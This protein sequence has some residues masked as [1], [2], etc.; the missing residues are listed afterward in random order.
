MKKTSTIF[1]L[2]WIIFQLIP[3]NN[4]I[5]QNCCPEFRLSDA[6]QICPPEGACHSDPVGGQAGS[7]AACKDLAHTYTVFPNDPTYTYTW[8]V[9]GG[10]AANAT[11]NPNI[12]VW[13][14][15]SL[16]FIKV[17]ISNVNF[18]G[19]CVDSIMQEICLIDGPEA[20]FN[21][22]QDTVCQ[23]TP[24]H[25]TNTSLGGS[26][27]FW[28][29]G[30]GSTSNLANPPDHSY[31][32][33]GTYTIILTAQDMG[34]G[35]IVG[36]TQGETI[37]PCGCIDTISKVVVVLPGQGP[38]IETDCCYGTVCPGDTSSFCT[39]SV[40]TTY[41]WLITGGN[42]ISGA[43]TNCIQVKWDN[44]YT[45]PSTV[46]LELPGCGSAPCGG[47]TTINVPVL[48]PNLPIIGPVI[49]CAGAS[50]SYSLPSLPGTYYN[51]TVSGGPYSFN[52][53][54]RN[55]A[56]VNI[57]FIAPGTY[58]VKCDYDN[59]LA[60]C[61]GVDSLQVDI[62]PEFIISGDAIV[63]EGNT[64]PYYANGAANWAAYPSGPAIAGNGTATINVT[65]TPGTYTLSAIPLNSSAFCNDSAVKVVEVITKPLLNNI[66]GPDSICPG[67][68]LTYSISSNLSGSP[69]VWTITGGM[70]LSQ[71][72]ADN[73][74]IVVKF[75]GTV[76]WVLNVYQEI[77]IS[78]G[79][80]CQSLT[81]TLNVYPF[82]PPNISG[83]TN[84]C[85]DAIETY[86]AG[87]SNPSGGFQW[88]ISPPS[89]GS[90]QSGQ[91]S[92]TVQILWHGT[93]N[94]AILKVKTCAGSAT[95]SITI[96][97]PPVKPTITPSA[98]SFYCLPS[99][100]N[101]L[102][103]SVPL[104]YSSYQWYHNGL[105]SGA[106]GNSYL[107][108]NLS[109][110]GAGT[111]VFSVVVSNGIC[112]VTSN[113]V[114]LI[115][116]CS[117]VGGD[118]I[119]PF[120]CP[121]IDFTMN[122]NPACENQQVTFIASPA[123][124]GYQLA[125]DFGD[126]STS[127]VSPTNH[128]YTSAG[129]Y[130]VKLTATLGTICILD[131]TKMI[132]VN[133]TPTCTIIPADTIYCPGDSVALTACGSMS[134][135]QWYKNGNAIPG[136]NNMTYYVKQHGEY[137]VE[138]DNNFGCTNNSDSIYIYEHKLPVAK[139]IGEKNICA[140]A[141]SSVQVFLYTNYNANYSYNWTSIPAGATFAPPTDYY[142]Y[143]SLT[144]P[145][146]LPVIYQFVVDVTDNL[147]MCHNSDT[148]CVTF[149]ANPV[150][151]VTYLN[152]C[153]GTLHT[154]TPSLIDP[155]NYSYQW[156]N[157]AT[158]PVITVS[159]PGFYSLIITD[160][161]SG[162][163]TTQDAGFIHANPDLSLFPLGCA[164]ICLT[165]TFHLYIP[166]P[167]DEFGI[168]S[169]YPGAY[170]DISWYANGNYGTPIG[171]GENL[172]YSPGFT[173][174]YQIS[175]VVQNNFGCI[176][177]AGVFC[178]S[179]DTTVTIQVSTETPCRCDSILTFNI[180]NANNELDNKF[181]SMKNC[182][183]DFTFCVNP[184]AT[185]NIIASNGIFIPNAIVNGVVTYPGGSS[186][187]HI[188][189]NGLCCFAY[190]D[191][192][193]VKILAPV[194]YTSD[195]VWDGK[196]YIDDNVIVTVSMGSVL[197]ITNVDV[198]FGECAGIV[199]Q[200]SS[201]LRTNNSVYRPC[202]ID[203]TWRGLR[204]EGIGEFD[205]IIN[206]STFKNAEVALYFKNGSDGVISNN[207]FS[208]CNYG[209]RVEGNNTFNHPISGNRF[210]TEQFF[211]SW[212]CTSRYSFVNDLS[213][214]GIYTSSSRF[215]AEV[216][217]N[218]FLNTW[219]PDYPRTYGIYQ[220]MG[221][222]LFSENTFTDLSYAVMLNSAMFPTNI[223]NNTI[224]VNKST[225]YSLASIYIDFSVN[226]VIEINNNKIANNSNQYNS[227]SAIYARSSSNISIA[228]NAIDGFSYGIIAVLARNFQI[229]KN[230]IE[231]CN[232]SGIYFYTPGN[233]NDRTYITCNTISMRNYSNTRGLFAINMS[234]LSVVT[235]NCITDCYTS[236]DFRSYSGY[237]PLPLIRNNFLYNYNQAGIN[238]QGHS[239]N[240]GTSA[241]PGMNTL[242]SNDN[243]AIDINS[244]TNIT[245]ADNFG[246]FNI[247]WPQVQITSNNPY[248]STASCALQIFNMPSQGNLN[249]SY[250][251]DHYTELLRPIKNTN[252]IYS[253][254][255]NY[256]EILKSTDDQFNLANLILS[257]I[258]DSNLDLLNEIIGLTNLTENEKSL[259]TYSFYYRIGELEQARTNLVKFIPRD[260]D[261]SD[262]Q[263]VRVIDLNVTENGWQ[264]LTDEDI[265]QLEIIREKELYNSNF[266]TS[267]LNNTATYRDYYAEEIIL[268]DVDK[269]NKIKHIGENENYLNIYPNPATEKVFIELVH[270][271][272]VDGELQLYNVSGERIKN[273]TTTLVAGGL[274]LDIHNL[275]KGFYF[276]TL[277]DTDSGFIQTGKLVKIEK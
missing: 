105:I 223:E 61:M 48:Y 72:G 176:D 179:V 8:T 28:D 185:Y 74:S 59:P 171:N 9:T 248:H 160:N 58:W 211:P 138:M 24:I 194:N 122:P 182:I 219:G 71:M 156:T 103:L 97:N 85:V 165:D 135:Y 38:E 26:V 237:K 150:F 197:D 100:P 206:E 222:G 36:G 91:G 163:S 196:Y 94:S 215:V 193:F 64:V 167:L 52:Q 227:F 235:N 60:G 178:I 174:N 47:T 128:I 82:L 260:S 113:I 46:S 63:C 256:Q 39:P 37:V 17:V 5:A 149:F 154:L 270:N 40:C 247:S 258:T 32:S 118:T 166:L 68:N 136:A 53:V 127:F 271:T 184:T 148:I 230:D 204:F 141:G 151:S 233:T 205:N 180:V 139:I 22:S 49:L 253:L 126:A 232:S 250:T 202:N 109:F 162:C 277:T 238:V 198:V 3:S 124:S 240:I 11:G 70:I 221:G 31:S 110:T 102:S 34:S 33:P 96:L 263:K 62:L 228:K 42:I 159:A 51:W 104:G 259:L 175:V 267:L 262:Y 79:V 119:P 224:E 226:P 264:V 7:L 183:E 266:A 189:D 12:I 66:I 236:M 192:L 155:A 157:G 57:T 210:V 112:S 170:N 45:V 254:A 208:N 190:A 242:Y 243:S 115:G 200:D 137:W 84:V 209:V 152:A 88:T 56:N 231:D 30:D 275:D 10:T 214:Y 54:D 23:N 80:F 86:T 261:E 218:E 203:K 76:P 16:G 164:S 143:A 229:S 83:Q 142:T 120:N 140:D 201:Y 67:K 90:I 107:I 273:F 19:N 55:S 2:L 93:P 65:W 181:F 195:V 43:G 225:I 92:N 234:P 123:V 239:G 131:T 111:Y 25:I 106:N 41:N 69:F 265:I 134:F 245:V 153:E 146:T 50:G 147:T 168:N 78:P 272:G 145:V 35:Q 129:T 220:T 172:A 44:T 268:P 89:Q 207:L 188:G 20:D 213:T 216:S 13:G 98:S 249:T 14:S 212:A 158:S 169:T 191:S 75:T 241:V 244:S 1:S 18:G 108:P 177:T 251:C 187:F 269:S 132:T 199:F 95:M 29:F 21:L 125:W 81:Q 186:P 6:V 133:P 27:Y 130:N 73:D 276:V 114:I 161:L 101:N 77:E 173:G 255:E 117:G 246:M 15:G 87:G 116:D 257:T 4:L 144:L 252:G 274:E 121:I 99:M 217:H